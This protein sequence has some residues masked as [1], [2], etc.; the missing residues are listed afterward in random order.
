MDDNAAEISGTKTPFVGSDNVKSKAK[1]DV[2]Q[3]RYKRN[4]SLW[5]TVFCKRQ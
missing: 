3:H 4:N 2:A 1:I 5:T